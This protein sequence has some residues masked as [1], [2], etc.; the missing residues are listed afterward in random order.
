MFVRLIP[1]NKGKRDGYY[2]SLVESKR[3]NGPSSHQVLYNFGFLDA[4]HAIYL[5]AA[6]SDADPE[7]VVKSELEKRGLKAK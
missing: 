3:V 7:G 5:K 1:D 2:C 6:F 4:I